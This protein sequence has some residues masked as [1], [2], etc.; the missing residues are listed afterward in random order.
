MFFIFKNDW[1]ALMLAA[2]AGHVSMVEYLHRQGGA[3]SLEDT[4]NVGAYTY[5]LFPP[6]LKTLSFPENC[7]V[8]AVR[9]VAV[10][11]SCLDHQKCPSIAEQ[12]GIIGEQ[13]A[14]AT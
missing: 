14:T 4:N 1:T 8:V 11:P 2:Q 5:H 3:Q 10:E 9:L 12:Q 13:Q 6:S 7:C